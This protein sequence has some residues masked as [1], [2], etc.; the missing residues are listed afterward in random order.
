MKKLILLFISCYFCNLSGLQAQSGWDCPPIIP[1]PSTHLLFF[2]DTIKFSI[3]CINVGDFIGAF[4]IDNGQEVCNAS[5]SWEDKDAGITV[6]GDDPL[7][8]EKEGFSAGEAI[9]IKVWNGVNDQSHDATAIYANP[10]DYFAVDAVGFFS[11]GS[12]SLIEELDIELNNNNNQ[13]EMSFKVLLEG[14]YQSDGLM[15]V[16]ALNLT[17]TQPYGFAP[18]NHNGNETVSSFPNNAIDWVLVEARSGTANATG[19]TKGTSVVETKVGFLL[20]NGSVVDPLTGSS[21]IFSNLVSGTSYYFCLRHRNHLD[22]LTSKKYTAGYPFLIDFTKNET[23]LGDNQL[24]LSNDGYLMMYT[25][26]FSQDGII[27]STDFD[28]WKLNPAAN[29]VY[30]VEDANLDGVIQITDYDFWFRNKAKLGI[31]EVRY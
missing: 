24:K 9:I 8:T 10:A 21:L 7:T 18:Y 13:T 14:P 25:G 11:D 6:F 28:L 2:P 4:H 1:N 17:N 20:E 22:I 15:Q 31:I 5:V 29:G 16:S 26:D 30:E 23:V 3:N 27:Q 19:S 12:I